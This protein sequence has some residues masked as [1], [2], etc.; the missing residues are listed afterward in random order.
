MKTN[1]NSSF[2]DLMH[3]DWGAAEKIS[4]MYSCPEDFLHTSLPAFD[5]QRVR[6]AS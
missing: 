5:P 4:E 2:I 1:A 6:H 3:L